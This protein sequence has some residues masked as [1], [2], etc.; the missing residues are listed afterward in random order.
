MVSH[1]GGPHRFF[2]FWSAEIERIQSQKRITLRG[3]RFC[4]AV[5]NTYRIQTRQK[6]AEADTSRSA[7]LDD[8]RLLFL[9]DPALISLAAQQ[10]GAKI[11]WADDVQAA[12][13]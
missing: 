1:L 13:V 9:K 5:I 6:I 4:E 8:L 10:V 12:S 11:V 3:L 2:A 7:I